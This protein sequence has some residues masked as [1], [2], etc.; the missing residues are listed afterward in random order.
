MLRRIVSMLF[1][2]YIAV[3]CAVLYCVALAIWLLTVLFDR[4]LVILHWFTC[5]WGSMYIW[6][7]PAWS[8]TVVGREKIP[9]RGSRV[10][11]SNHQSQL[12]IL[13]CF[14]LFFHYKWV[15][16]EE[17][18]RVPFI[19]WNM[20]LN[21]YIRL[22]RGDKESVMQM[23]AEAEKA[24]DQG[25]PVFFF[26]EGTRSPDGRVKAFK[27]GAFYLARKTKKP[28][29]P[30]AISGTTN[31]LPKKSMNFHGFHKI[32]VTILD[33]IPYEN[34]AGLTD[35]ETA[36]MVRN[37]IIEHVADHHREPVAVS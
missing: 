27:P 9:R 6:I 13:V 20:T 11:V 35:E 2:S 4:R 25:S 31:A 5:L 36:E 18:F 33:E 7:M 1:I 19:G 34:F 29:L 16:K 15:S 10:I 12:D 28:I 17:M 26:P 21:R 22:K 37:R 8:V 30:I 24:L 3:S 23:L 14:T 32:R